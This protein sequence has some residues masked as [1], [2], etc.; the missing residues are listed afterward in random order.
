MATTFD[1]RLQNL[2]RRRQGPSS[3]AKSFTDSFDA[4]SGAITEAY[5]TRSTEK[6]TR[7]ALGAMQA[8]DA[9]YTANSV[10]EGDRVKNQLT[11]GLEGI[12]DV[13]FEYQGS[14]P[15]D[16]HIKGVSDIDLLVLRADYMTVDL[17]GAHNRAGRYSDWVGAQT[18][19]ELLSELRSESER[20][21]T[22]AFPEADV[23]TAGAKSISLTGGSLRRKID[24]VPAHWHDTE[25][26]QLT[27]QRKDRGVRI[28]DK[29]NGTTIKNYPFLHIHLIHQKDLET[30][31][32]TKKAIRLLKNVKEDSGYGN[33][34][35]LSSYDI[36][37]LVWHFDSAALTAYPWAE[38]S[39]L[40]TLRRG[41]ETLTA[42]KAHCMALKT[43]DNSRC[44]IDSEAKFAS[45]LL[46]HQE[47]DSLA[48]AV[49]T[50]VTGGAPI[51]D[52]SVDNRLRTAVVQ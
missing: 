31:G 36:A 17:N 39:I 20:L 33:A 42:N 37:G 25:T 26:Y 49:A 38:L 5:E 47:L 40:A 24:V 1:N 22:S 6:A 30:R 23:D 3:I 51:L 11:K 52:Q 14:V 10:A 35:S 4:A 15:L 27:F 8:V 34:I 45:L 44:I 29:T 16:V 41:F 50:E 18:G 28:L 43:P 7:Y 46:L 19:P 48:K 9:A 21:L 13:T 32:G 12:V 2:K